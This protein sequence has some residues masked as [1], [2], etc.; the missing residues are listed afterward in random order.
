MVYI[1]LD[2]RSSR[3]VGWAS[4]PLFSAVREKNAGKIIRDTYHG[5]GYLVAIAQYIGGKRAKT[6]PG[7][8]GTM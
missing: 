2:F 4:K 8:H 7:R 3:P 1:G 6:H 5:M